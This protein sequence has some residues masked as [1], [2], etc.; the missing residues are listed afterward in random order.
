MNINRQLRERQT[1]RLRRNSVKRKS[2]AWR[3]SVTVQPESFIRSRQ[4]LPDEILAINSFVGITVL[5]R[6]RKDQQQIF[7]FC[8]QYTACRIQP[9]IM[10]S[11]KRRVLSSEKVTHLEPA[12][13]ALPRQEQHRRQVMTSNTTGRSS[14]VLR[15]QIS[16]SHMDFRSFR[17]G[18]K[19]VFTLVLATSC[20]AR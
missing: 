9:E 11:H 15:T 2:A 7:R 5:Q 17:K 1:Q 10:I 12:I 6:L 4:Q 20:L 13:N 16:F 19:A 14:T 3:L 8:R 18:M